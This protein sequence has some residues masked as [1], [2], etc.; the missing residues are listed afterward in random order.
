MF[1]L[2]L[3]SKW[4]WIE[5]ADATSVPRISLR[6]AVLCAD[7]GSITESRHSTC[8]VCGGRGITLLAPLLAGTRDLIGAAL[9]RELF[10]FHR[11]PEISPIIIMEG[12]D[13]H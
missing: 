4:G 6:D 2:K 3:L 8:D 1:L 7:C 13:K 5:D 10:Y 11:D 9:L 12:V